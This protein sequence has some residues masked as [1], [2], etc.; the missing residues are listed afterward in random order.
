MY[1][2]LQNKGF[3]ADDYEVCLKYHII[4]ADNPPVPLGKI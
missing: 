4:T 3:G 2:F 1:G